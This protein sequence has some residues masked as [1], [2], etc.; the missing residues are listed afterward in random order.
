[1][2]VAAPDDQADESAPA[3]PSRREHRQLMNCF[4]TGVV[5][6]TTFDADDSPRGITCTSVSSVASAP[7]TLMASL[8]TRSGT[9]AAI[10]RRGWFAVNFLDAGAQAAAELFASAEWDRFGRVSWARS[11]TVGAPWLC[12]DVVA[13]AECRVRE[14]LLVGDHELVL[15]EVVRVR[16]FGG[17]PLVY[18]MRQFVS[19]PA[20]PAAGP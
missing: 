17:T 11:D 15:G 7:P 1:M 16:L 9:L 3:R 4:P 10:R 20:G 6:V 5:V 19:W 18:G 8:N 14:V 2:T 12:D 13:L